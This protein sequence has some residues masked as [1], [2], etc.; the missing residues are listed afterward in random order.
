MWFVGSWYGSGGAAGN[1]GLRGP[2]VWATA[3]RGAGRLNDKT[4]VP[5]GRA[6]WTRSRRSQKYA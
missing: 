3:S 1:M 6:V 2:V 5:I 4:P